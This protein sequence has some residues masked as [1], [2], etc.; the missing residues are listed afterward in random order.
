MDLIHGVNQ[1]STAAGEKAT[2]GKSLSA[3]M[4][5]SLRLLVHTHGQADL[6]KKK[7]KRVESYDGK[8]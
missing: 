2:L 5:R 1:E 6:E 8:H 4:L 3:S 7:N